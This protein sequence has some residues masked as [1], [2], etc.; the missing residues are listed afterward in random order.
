MSTSRPMFVNHSGRYPPL[1]SNSTVTPSARNNI[2]ERNLA[3]LIFM[4]DPPQHESSPYEARS[5]PHGE[6]NDDEWWVHEPR[7]RLRGIV[8]LTRARL[9]ARPGAAAWA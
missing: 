5:R 9:P 4:L 3:V 2:V 6:S 1:R 7:S 8:E